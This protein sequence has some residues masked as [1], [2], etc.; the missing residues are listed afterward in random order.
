MEGTLF[1]R[2]FICVSLKKATVERMLGDLQ[3]SASTPQF[4]PR[5]VAG[6]TTTTGKNCPG[7]VGRISCQATT[8]STFQEHP[9]ALGEEALKKPA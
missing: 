1:N 9:G 8:L 3:L 6:A 4:S 7:V 5:S 2:A